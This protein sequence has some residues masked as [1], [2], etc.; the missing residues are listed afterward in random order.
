M[1]AVQGFFMSFGMVASA[2]EYAAIMLIGAGA[3][4]V[5]MI[6]TTVVINLRYF[7]MSCSLSQKLKPV[8]RS[9]SASC[10]RSV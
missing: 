2:G 4:I 1:S 7:L 5:E 9:G 10:W 8:H 6:T 3:G